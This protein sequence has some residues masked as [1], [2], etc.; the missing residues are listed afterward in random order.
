MPIIPFDEYMPD[1]QALDNP[2]TQSVLNVIPSP[3]GYRPLRSLYVQ[4]S[5]ITARCQGGISAQDVSGN[6]A[7]FVGDA[8]KLYKQSGSS[9][10]DVSRSSGGAYATPS[11]DWWD[12]ALYGNNV[13]ATNGIDDLQYIDITSGTNFAAVAG[14]PPKA[15][16]MCAVREF[17]MLGN[18][19]TAGYPN[20]LHWSASGSMTGWTVG[21]NESDVSDLPDNGHI[22][23]MVGGEAAYIF[24]ERAITVASRVGAP[25]TF[26]LDT[27]VVGIGTRAPKSVVKIGNAAFFFADDGFYVFDGS[28]AQPI[29]REKVDRSVTSDI[30]AAYI[31]RITAASDPV[32]KLIY[33]AYPSASSSDGT[34]DKVLIYNWGIGRWAPATFSVEF[35]LPHLSAG[36]TL[37]ELDAFGTMDSLT[38]SLDDR[39]WM[40]GATSLRAFNTS[41]IL[42]SLSGDTL[43]ATLETKEVEPDGRRGFV[44]GL[45]PRVDASGATACVGYRETLGASVSYTTPTSQDRTGRCPQRINGRYLRA[46]VAVPAAAT[47]TFATGVDVSI[48]PDGEA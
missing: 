42:C 3:V 4:T 14:S 12:F 25:I 6:P 20:R 16:R 44:N 21:T 38:V 19:P 15:R 27:V 9:F 43:A 32:N 48:Q 37:E 10:S 47:W 24:Q 41:H 17:L 31:H 11:T 8:T 36:Y 40:G 39:F 5:A 7:T 1:I 18:L 45:R 34:P 22:T 28:S 33:W 2:G 46:K 23:A 30:N 26:Q 13:V 35:F 29:G